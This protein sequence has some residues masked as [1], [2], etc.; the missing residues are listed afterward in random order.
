MSLLRKRYH[1]PD[2]IEVEEY[3]TARHAPPG[4][5]RGIKKKPTREQMEK[6]NQRNKEKAL[7]RKML[8]NFSENDYF[9][10]LT[11]EVDK[12][13]ADMKECQQQ[14]SKFIR[15]LRREY[16]KRGQVLKWM[17]TIE[18]GSRG[19]WHIHLVVNRIQDTDLIIKRLWQQGEA[20]NK[21][22][23]KDQGKLAAYLAKTPA[24]TKAVT[25][26]S[27]SC[28]RNLIVPKPDTKV[29][30]IRTFYKIRV[31]KGYVLDTDT[32]YEGINECTG[33]PWR[34]YTLM[35]IMTEKRRE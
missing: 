10:T 11:Y 23:R 3:H 6:V 7:R 25:E 9:S 28:S 19:A 21:L 35:K 13:P 5:K 22:I 34:Y 33:Y 31:P 26:T 2:R 16:A 14:A 4:I 15:A 27:F 32:L 8:M 17:R 24:T 29:I 30:S 18:V 20:Y 1:L 12:R